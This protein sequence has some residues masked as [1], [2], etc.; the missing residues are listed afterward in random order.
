MSDLN[1]DALAEKAKAATPGP[2][3]LVDYAGSL[4][5][6]S[7]A[8]PCVSVIAADENPIYQ[9][10]EPEEGDYENAR[11]ISAL[12]PD[13][14]LALI[15]RIREAEKRVLLLAAGDLASEEELGLYAFASD[16]KHQRERAEK[17]EAER[18]RLAATVA[19]VRA[20]GSS[21]LTQGLGFQD[22]SFIEGYEMAHAA[23]HAALEADA[24]P[25][26]DEK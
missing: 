20:V 1:L 7:G 8:P 16:A 14:A 21:P 6:H 9:N 3:R 4:L 17:A 11:F 22:Q 13:V 2:W 5:R 23:I 19:R 15:A 25:A 24:A 10:I 12:S 18:D 26:G